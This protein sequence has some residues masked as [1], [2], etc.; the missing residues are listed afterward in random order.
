MLKI[1]LILFSWIGLIPI[2]EVAGLFL[3]ISKEILGPEIT[4]IFSLGIL[5]FSKIY[6]DIVFFELFSKPLTALITT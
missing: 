5:N 3:Y 1:L 4:P 2:T 6:R